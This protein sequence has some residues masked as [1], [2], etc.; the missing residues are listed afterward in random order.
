MI[1]WLLLEEG[2][3]NFRRL[4]R[5]LLIMPL[6]AGVLLATVGFSP[7]VTAQQK[8][9]TTQASTTDGSKTGTPTGF[10]TGAKCTKTGTYQ[11]ENKYM[12][13][14]IVVAEGEE[15]PPFA[16]GQNT[17][18]Y[19]LTPSFKSTFEAIKATTTDPK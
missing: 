14:V 19:A 13:V 5:R 2:K 9:Q 15:F 11:A 17:T 4:S 16:D 1:A 3:M 8:E 18:W 6:F 12:K 10:L 7:A